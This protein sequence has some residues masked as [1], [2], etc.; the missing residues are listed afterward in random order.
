M[1]WS[2]N[3]AAAGRMEIPGMAGIGVQAGVVA[4]SDIY[5]QPASPTKV[6]LSLQYPGTWSNIIVAGAMLYLVAIYVGALRIAGS[7]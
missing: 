5:A 7:E 6:S 4:G 3:R 2:P 1:V